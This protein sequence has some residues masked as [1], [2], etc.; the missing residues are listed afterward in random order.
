MPIDW[1]AVQS[2]VDRA[3]EGAT[4]RTNDRLA[5]KISSLTRMTDVEVKELFPTPADVDKLT[6]LMQ[7]VKSADQ[8]NQ[9]VNQLINNIEVLGGTVM[10]LLEKFA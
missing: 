5:S 4:D 1:D 3:L 2:E 9:K 7:I 8:R 10:S 6:K